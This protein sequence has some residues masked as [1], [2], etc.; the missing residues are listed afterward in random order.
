MTCLSYGGLHGCQGEHAVIAAFHVLSLV[1]AAPTQD[2]VQHRP[3]PEGINRQCLG[4]RQVDQL[5]M[6]GWGGI[7]LLRQL[8]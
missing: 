7:Y 4:E 6:R 2:A 5:L 8:L 1:G 3:R